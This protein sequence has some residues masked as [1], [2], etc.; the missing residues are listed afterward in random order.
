MTFPFTTKETKPPCPKALIP[1]MSLIF[2]WCK[3][4]AM[5]EREQ[6]LVLKLI[7]NFDA[8]LQSHGSLNIDCV[9]TIPASWHTGIQIQTT[10]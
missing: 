9:I 7:L 1:G 8:Y 4:H 10:I 5:K 6:F 3:S 2:L